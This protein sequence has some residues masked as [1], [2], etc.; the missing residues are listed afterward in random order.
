V[1]EECRIHPAG[2]NGRRSLYASDYLRRFHYDLIMH[3]P[4]VSRLLADL[5]SADR[6]GCGTDFAQLMAI[7]KSVEFVEAI[8][9]ITARERRLILCENPARLRRL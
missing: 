4:K 2:T 5:V 7:M 6:A 3:D 1:N 8:P 9:N